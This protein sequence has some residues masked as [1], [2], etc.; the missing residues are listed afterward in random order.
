MNF[1]QESSHYSLLR[2][3]CVSLVLV[4]FLCCFF[5]LAAYGFAENQFD[6]TV[7]D[8]ESEEQESM[9]YVPGEILVVYKADALDSVQAAPGN[10][11]VQSEVNAQF[12]N[13]AVYDPQV[14]IVSVEAGEEEA[15]ILEY[16]K[17]PEVLFAQPNY[18]YQCLD[19]IPSDPFYKT[20]Q[21]TY[22]QLINAEKGWSITKGDSAVTIAVID[23]GIN[24]AH[25]DLSG[26][27]VKQA[28]TIEEV[29]TFDDAF[30][31]DV[32][33]HGTHVAGIIAAQMNNALGVTGIA[34]GC[35]IMP[36][37]A[38]EYNFTS[39]AVDRAIRY[40]VHNGADV[41]SMSLGG[42]SF[43]PYL[44]NACYFA[45]ENGVVVLVAAG[46]DNRTTY[47]YPA[48]NPTVIGVT[49]VDHSGNSANFTRNASVKVAA[50]GKDIYSTYINGS[51]SYKLSGGTSQATPMVAA[52]CGLIISKHPGITPD[53]VRQML[54]STARDAGTKGYDV[55]FGYGILDMYAV[56]QTTPVKSDRFEPNNVYGLAT[57]I[58]SRS[59]TN[60]N[61]LYADDVDVYQFSI[62]ATTELKISVTAPKNLAITEPYLISQS[63]AVLKDLFSYR[64]ENSRALQTIAADSTFEKT[65]TLAPGTYFISM[66]AV[67]RGTFSSEEYKLVLN[68]KGK[69]DNLEILP[70]ALMEGT[71]AKWFNT[72]FQTQ[73]YQYTVTTAE[74]S[75]QFKP[76][77][78]DSKNVNIKINGESVANNSYSSNII[79]NSGAT[80]VIVE[81]ENLIGMTTDAKY[82]IFIQKKKELKLSKLMPDNGELVFHED[83][84]SYD[85][86]ATDINAPVCFDLMTKEENTT[87]KIYDMQNYPDGQP[88]QQIESSEISE[89]ILYHENEMERTVL[90]VVGDD[91]EEQTIYEVRILWPYDASLSDIKVQGE[92]IDGFSETRYEYSHEVQIDSNEILI[93]VE[94]MDNRAFIQF[95]GVL[96]EGDTFQLPISNGETISVVIEV[97][98][99]NVLSQTYN[100][101]IHCS[102]DQQS[103]GSTD[104]N[105]DEND[106]NQNGNN[107]NKSG[108]ADGS[109]GNAGEDGSNDGNAD[110]IN[111][112]NTGEIGENSDGVGGG[113]TSGDDE[114]S[115]ENAGEDS[116]NDGDVDETNNG[117]TGENDG[118][119][120][121]LGGG[122]P[123]GGSSGGAPDIA[124]PASLEKKVEEE[125]L[126][127]D[128]LSQVE[129]QEVSV[130]DFLT[131]ISGTGK[132]IDIPP[133][134][135]K[136]SGNQILIDLTEM[137]AQIQ[138][139]INLKAFEKYLK[140]NKRTKVSDIIIRMDDVEYHVP[141]NITGVI[142]QF[143]E[144]A[145]EN[146]WKQDTE[147]VFQI[148]MRKMPIASIL[149]TEIQAESIVGGPVKI[150]MSIFDGK[151]I[152]PIEQFNQ[153]LKFDVLLT[154]I[155]EA[156][157]GKLAAVRLPDDDSSTMELST[158]NYKLIQ[159]DGKYFARIATLSNSIYLIY[160]NP[161]EFIDL[162]EHWAK[163][164]IEE[165]G[166]RR[167][168]SGVGEGRYE[169]EGN[170]TRAEFVT[171]AI[172]AL[173]LPTLKNE[174]GADNFQSVYQDV[175]PDAWFF[176]NVLNAQRIGLLN[177]VNTDTF[178]PERAITR[179]EMAKVIWEA[180][181]YV[182]KS[183]DKIYELNFADKVFMDA[184]IIPAEDRA[185]IAF[186]VEYGIMN[187][188][189]TD[190]EGVYAIEPEGV[191]T[192]AQAAA[193]TLRMLRSLDLI[194]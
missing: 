84:T 71:G 116:S 31:N 106:D 190:V 56:L 97:V 50:P 140:T 125:L 89:P 24:L 44:L 153:Y 113:G 13:D 177:W 138:L 6:V 127:T 175:L 19:V 29:I 85:L 39:A 180:S 146:K 26:V 27:C 48:S 37:K 90:F 164:E 105:T 145:K 92:S 18:V 149:N 158:R 178:L 8:L 58:A 160:R 17:D 169:P 186:C 102:D 96:Q 78:N 1:K 49:G 126:K 93:E 42:E 128:V 107:E 179:V 68:H 28:N 23:T 118:N 189:T 172:R 55:V 120:G 156:D 176:G 161:S 72:N 36:I 2:F 182:D 94:N 53:E 11:Y 60:A 65:Y 10:L 193:M 30:L 123:S 104:G 51:N 25:E 157:F 136:I 155:L 174:S 15:E 57:P 47:E 166:A 87:V 142:A 181:K 103:D 41:I 135:I 134:A 75:V 141:A 38:G 52:V 147:L 192:R 83:T 61:F 3:R 95:N 185:A 35:K 162:N 34:P 187:G 54:Y 67:N 100:L 151:T 144:L 130:L 9:D 114:S 188:T 77:F 66:S 170:V 132:K 69:L 64:R 112:G 33:G 46:N 124:D 98:I 137:N 74:K 171:M 91:G 143:D 7:F 109:G 32:S 111:D 45:E 76:T 5:S 79:L 183:K 108:D 119:T 70:D 63:S 139:N 163:K 21:Q 194:G 59:E 133:S 40:A 184:D 88:L 16:M 4:V 115:A 73:S 131:G 82:E 22:M 150:E 81:V 129:E 154:G 20:Y 99:P 152:I 167:I 12:E 80:K 101:V 168:V 122:V 110:E 121:G 148:S 165:A 191:T 86:I 14:Q 117:N 173:G 62:D 43:D 159:K